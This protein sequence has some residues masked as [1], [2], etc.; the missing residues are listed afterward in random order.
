MSTTWYGDVMPEPSWLTDRE[1]AAW[2]GYRRMRPLLDLRLYRD[3]V[4]QSGLSEADYDVLSNLSEAEGQRMRL[5]D[6]ATHM[7]WTKSR[8]SHHISRMQDRGLVTREECAE[9]GRGSMLVLTPLGR[10]TIVAAAPHHVASVREHFIDVLTPEEIDVLAAFTQRVIT[11][12][13]D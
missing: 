13:R 5:T 4:R 6:L 9:D 12:L 1:M 11:R 2:I 3:L 10:E 8:L 7:S